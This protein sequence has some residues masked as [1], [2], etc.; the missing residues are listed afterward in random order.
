[1]RLHS[2]GRMLPLRFNVGDA[3]CNGTERT[4]NRSLGPAAR[5]FHYARDFVQAHVTVAAT[6]PVSS[7]QLHLLFFVC[8]YVPLPLPSQLQLVSHSS[9]RIPKSHLGARS[10]V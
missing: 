8:V 7:A 5:T 2:L 10:Y 4:L 1:M 6:T 9:T 3:T